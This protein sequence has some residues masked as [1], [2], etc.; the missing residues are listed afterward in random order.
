MIHAEIVSPIF[1]LFLPLIPP[2]PIDAQSRGEQYGE[3]PVFWTECGTSV[4]KQRYQKN[5]NS[6]SNALIATGAS[7]A[8]AGAM[9]HMFR[10]TASSNFNGQAGL[11]IFQYKTPGQE[12][13]A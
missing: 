8:F 4:Y 5:K 6:A 13:P 11:T 3:I 9:R 1:C 2:M 7:L 12:P 10:K